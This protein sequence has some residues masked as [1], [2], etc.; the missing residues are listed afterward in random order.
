MEKWLNAIMSD[1]KPQDQDK[2][3]VRLTEGMRDR[4]KAASER[5]N[6]SMNAEIVATLETAYPQ[7]DEAQIALAAYVRAMTAGFSSADQDVVMQHVR[8][9]AYRS[10]VEAIDELER[11]S[12]SAP[13]QKRA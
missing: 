12:I 5:N 8:T 9:A 1:R 4:I 3:I 10:I 11:Q 13:E 2:F 7:I 6:R